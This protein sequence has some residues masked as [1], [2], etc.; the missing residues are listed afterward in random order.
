[1]KLA[2]KYLEGI[3]TIPLF[4]CGRKGFGAGGTSDQ[5]RGNRP[6]LAATAAATLP[7]YNVSPQE[8][9]PAAGR[10]GLWRGGILAQAVSQLR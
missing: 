1:M 8:G 9:G 4:V 6:P 10:G 3:S 5:I 2:F 7:Q